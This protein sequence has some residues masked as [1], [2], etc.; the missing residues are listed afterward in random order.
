MVRGE[1]G[2]PLTDNSTRLTETVFF[3]LVNRLD[4]ETL[5]IWHVMSYKIQ[6][7]GWLKEVK[8]KIWF[9][10]TV[11][12]TLVFY[13]DLNIKSFLF[14]YNLNVSYCIKGQVP[15]SSKYL[16]SQNSLESL[17][18]DITKYLTLDTFWKNRL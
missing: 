16:K 15:W 1:F 6:L 8:N 14:M 5:W 2:S 11:T 12:Q 9:F 3:G 13:S 10:N 4:E 7:E 18:D 17:I